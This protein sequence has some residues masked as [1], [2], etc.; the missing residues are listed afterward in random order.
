MTNCE[1]GVIAIERRFKIVCELFM[2]S[3][4]SKKWKKN[5]K[6]EMSVEMVGRY[7]VISTGHRPFAF[8]LANQCAVGEL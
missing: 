2:L 4:R 7:E 3:L 1:I 6:L 5:K 8:P